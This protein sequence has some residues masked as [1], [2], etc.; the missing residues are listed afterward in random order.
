MQPEELMLDFVG[1]TGPSGVPQEKG[2]SRAPFLLEAV[3]A[4][5]GFQRPQL[6]S[7]R[8]IEQ[9]HHL[10]AFIVFFGGEA[11]FKSSWK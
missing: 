2:C 11:V 1:P 5:H 10:P 4:Q 9:P 8:D 6:I 7:G 3:K